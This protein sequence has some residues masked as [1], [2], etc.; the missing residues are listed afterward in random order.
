[1]TAWCAVCVS[2]RRGVRV[3]CCSYCHGSQ[4]WR[5]KGWCERT[6]S[7]NLAHPTLALTLT[8]YS[9]LPYPHNPHPNHTTKQSSRPEFTSVMCG[10]SMLTQQGSTPAAHCYCGYQ[11]G[12]FAGQL[13]DGA[14]GCCSWC[15]GAKMC[16]GWQEV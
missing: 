13:G 7:A 8:L 16:F 3:H 6:L 9:L 12:Y 1:M 5:K 2:K 10:N 11:F 14:G 4:Q 15:V